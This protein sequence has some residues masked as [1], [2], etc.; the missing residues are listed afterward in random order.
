MLHDTDKFDLVFRLALSHAPLEQRPAFYCFFA[1]DQKLGQIV[2]RASEPMLAQLRLAWWR[3]ELA[4]PAADR[5]EGNPLLDLIGVAW[6]DR[7]AALSALVDGWEQ[8]LAEPPLDAAAMTKFAEGRAAAFE[9]LDTK[10]SDRPSG[11]VAQAAR[12]WALADLLL[13]SSDAEERKT[14]SQLMENT[15]TG[16]LSLP[17]SMRPLA[18]LHGLATRAVRRGEPALLGSRRASLAALRLGIFGR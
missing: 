3:D 2:A 5:P 13:H 12:R 18:I 6:R 17:K 14:L 10:A 11:N 4:K 9:A 8:L 16:P 7:E 1:L 15:G